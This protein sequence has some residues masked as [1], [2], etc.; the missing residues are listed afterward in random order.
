MSFNC[1]LE[2]TANH[3]QQQTQFF[4]FV[5]LFIV[6]RNLQPK[7]VNSLFFY[8]LILIIMFFGPQMVSTSTAIADEK[9]ISSLS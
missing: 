9:E 2:K 1:W 7:S 6:N 5:T 3:K 8:L 4:I